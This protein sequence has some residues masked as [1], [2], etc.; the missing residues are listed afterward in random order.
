MTTS[1]YSG[2]EIPTVNDEHYLKVTRKKK[3]KVTVLIL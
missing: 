1:I 2:P 3:I